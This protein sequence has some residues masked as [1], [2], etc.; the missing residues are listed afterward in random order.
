M[1]ADASDPTSVKLVDFGLCVEYDNL[2]TDYLP[3]QQC[4]TL[5][6]MAPEVVHKHPYSK[7]VDVWSLGIT[8]YKLIS[9]QHPLHRRGDP[10][11][12]FRTKIRKETPIVMG[13]DF[14]RL[15]RDFI[16]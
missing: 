9:G 13:D 6:Y 7:S 16:S 3:D 2:C 8:L 1:V 10:A 14:T 5:I 15:S 4:G 11:S 12:T